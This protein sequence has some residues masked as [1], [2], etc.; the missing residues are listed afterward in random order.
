ML[1]TYVVGVVVGVCLY[2]SA[3]CDAFLNMYMYC[4]CTRVVVMEREK[5]EEE[6][7]VDT[8]FGNP[9]TSKTTNPAG[10]L[11]YIYCN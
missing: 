9:N 6:E 8:W 10:Y 4:V 2:M 1:C 5:E 11:Y 7:G 3:A